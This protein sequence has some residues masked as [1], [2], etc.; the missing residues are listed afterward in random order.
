MASNEKTQRYRVK[1]KVF[2]NDVLI[3]PKGDKNVFVM[4]R[5]GLEGKALEAVSSGPAKAKPA[6]TKDNSDAEAS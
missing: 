5:P 6:K 4:A 3:D 1:A 2:V